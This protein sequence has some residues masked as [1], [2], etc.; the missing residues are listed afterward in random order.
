[1]SLFILILEHLI[2]FLS[3][4]EK[5]FF[6]LSKLLIISSGLIL[7]LVELIKNE[8]SLEFMKF[9]IVYTSSKSKATF[10]AISFFKELYL[11]S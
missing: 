5:S 9:S 4:G 1:M 11:S 6:K 7:L 8:T 2:T 10:L 3:L